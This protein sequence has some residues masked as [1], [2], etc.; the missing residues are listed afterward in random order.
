[1]RGWQKEYK[2]YRAIQDRQLMVMNERKVDNLIALE[3]AE[4]K[5][6]QPSLL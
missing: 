4:R 5:K 6:K 1:M 2:K 3:D